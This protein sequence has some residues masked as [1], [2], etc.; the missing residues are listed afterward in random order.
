MATSK[1]TIDGF[2]IDDG[3]EYNNNLKYEQI[4]K[5]SCNFHYFDSDTKM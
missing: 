3:S 1:I 5:L 2:D 4:L